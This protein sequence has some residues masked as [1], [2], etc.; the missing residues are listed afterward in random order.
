MWK[1]KFKKKRGEVKCY[2]CVVSHSWQ[3][4]VRESA[5]W[6]CAKEAFLGFQKLEPQRKIKVKVIDD[7]P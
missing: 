4:Q 6:V 3:V 7:T 1:R 5:G 2:W